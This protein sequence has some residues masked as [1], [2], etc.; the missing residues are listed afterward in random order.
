MDVKQSHST[1]FLVIVLFFSKIFLNNL[2]QCV[3]II[4]KYHSYLNHTNLWGKLIFV[5]FNFFQ[6]EIAK[7]LNAICAQIIPFLSQD[8]SIA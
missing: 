6:T 1:V 8:V 4:V 3:Q 7:R 2:Y 5:Y